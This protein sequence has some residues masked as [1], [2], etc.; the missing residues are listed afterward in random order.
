MA[1][2]AS[3]AWFGLL[4]GT[5]PEPGSD[6]ATTR[7]RR[8]WGCL[9]IGLRRSA[10]DELPMI[11]RGILDSM[12]RAAPAEALQLSEST[13][14]LVKLNDRRANLMISLNLLV[15]RFLSVYSNAK[16]SANCAGVATP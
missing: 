2:A 16:V 13:S 9:L 4:I 3:G 6:T 7:G 11:F 15:T 10:F 5:L 12:P 14:P 8:S 1:G